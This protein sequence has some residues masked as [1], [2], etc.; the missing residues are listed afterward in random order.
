VSQVPARLVYDDGTDPEKVIG[1][2]QPQDPTEGNISTF[3]IEKMA[4][5]YKRVIIEGGPTLQDSMPTELSEFG[6]EEPEIIV[7]V[8]PNFDGSWEDRLRVYPGEEGTTN[9]RG[10]YKNKELWGFKKYQGED[11]V[12]TGT[13]STNLTDALD[14]LLPDGYTPRY[15][16]GETPPNVTN[17][18]FSGARQQGFR[19]LQRYYEHFIIFTNETDGSDNYYVD[20]EPKGFGGVQFSLNRGTDAYTYNYW[21][22]GDSS[23]VVSKVKVIGKDSN[24]DKIERV[25]AA[26]AS[27]GVH[28]DDTDVDV[29]LGSPEPTRR[30]FRRIHVDYTITATEADNIAENVIVAEAVEQGEIEYELNVDSTLNQS[31]GIVDNNR[32]PDNPIDDVFTVVKQKDFLHQGVTQYSF[33][34]EKEATQEQVDKW[35]EHDFERAS[36]YPTQ[37][38]DQNIGPISI[39]DSETDTELV[40]EQ[41][42]ADTQ[43]DHPHGNSNSTADAGFIRATPVVD[44]FLTQR[45]ITAGSQ[46]VWTFSGLNADVESDPAFITLNLGADNVNT[47]LA[48]E[49]QITFGAGTNTYLNETFTTGF[50][51]DLM[52]GIPIRTS[53]EGLTIEEVEITIFNY[54]GQNDQDVAGPIQI[55]AQQD[56]DHFIPIADTDGNTA[57][58]SIDVNNNDSSAGDTSQLTVSGETVEELI[59]ILQTIEEKKSMVRSFVSTTRFQY[60]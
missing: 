29:Y 5:N 6:T 15:A 17:Y 41:Y 31:V 45:T 34:F 8:D 46:E 1:A 47:D 22:K 55:L 11:D 13:V 35:T 25:V 60:R 53:F 4:K 2:F 59:N 30:K 37:S 7:Q 52:T 43:V 38:D 49:V 56:H 23:N 3:T 16:S 40:S 48:I 10:R 57:D 36:V 12:D 27:D 58:L 14:A 33:E 18:S 32:T 44:E 51:G 21:K 50:G 20:L 28:G 9:D 42:D 26:G 19:E 54:A 39:N 24:G